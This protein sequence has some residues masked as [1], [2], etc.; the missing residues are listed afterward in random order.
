MDPYRWQRISRLYHAALA[1]ESDRR[2]VF[3]NEACHDDDLR[4]EVE[5]L[6]ASGPGEEGFLDASPVA[7]AAHLFAQAEGLPPVRDQIGAYKILG[8][9]GAGGMGEI[10]RAHDGKLGRDVALKVLPRQLADDPERRARML[11][12]ARAA[13][14][15]NHPNICT[16][17]E[18]G[19]ADGDIYIAMEVIDGEPL[20]ARP[21]GRLLSPEE[22]VRIG[23]QL[24]DAVA[25][26]HD[27]GIVH[28]DLKSGNVMV[29]PEG[30][31]K[32]LDFGLAKRV[33]GEELSD[34]T[35][36]TDV[37]TRPQTILGTLPYMSPEQLRGQTAD[38]RSDVWALGVILYEM[39]AGSR[40][41]DGAT[42]FEMS[43]AIL[44]QTPPAL[45]S[46][47]SVALETVI[48]RCL[49]KEPARRYQRAAEVRAA[50]ETLRGDRVTRAVPLRVKAS[51]SMAAA[52]AVLGVGAAL[53]WV[54]QPGATDSV[55]ILPFINES[56]DPELDYL[57]DGIT[58]TLINSLSQLPELAVMSRNSVFRYKGRETDAQAAG[59]TLKVQ[60]VITGRVLQ[61]GDALSIRAELIDVDSN[62]QL[63]GQQYNRKLVDILTM[64]E[65]ISTQISENLRLRLTGEERKQL[66]KRYTEN[67][68]AYQHYLRGLYHWN[69]RTPD[70]FNRSIEYFQKATAADPNYAPAHAGL[71]N[72]YTNQANYNF[73]LVPPREAWAKAKAASDRALEIDDTL[74]AAH[75]A[76]AL[77]AYQ[78]EWN[79][80]LAE[81][82]FRRA[83]ELDPTSSAT[84]HWYAHYLMTV[85][86][87]EDALKAGRRALELDPLDLPSNAHQGWHYLWLRQYDQAIEPLQM[88]L[89]LAPMFSVAQWYL[90]LAYEQQGAYQQ[91]IGQF[92]NCIRLTDGN[93]S[94]V[95]LLGHAYAAANRRAEAR[96][97]LEQLAVLSKQHYVPSYPV[98]T[99]HAALG[100]KDEAFARLERAYDERDS[101]MDYLA[102][103]PRLDGLR[104]DPRFVNLLRRMNLETRGRAG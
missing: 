7:V 30:R 104:S 34:V 27:R 62:R 46:R 5:S 43:S 11:R 74:A 53:Y 67:T 85:G 72:V 82:E 100:E 79:W 81:K 50:L 58:E 28:R 42:Q 4:R 8:L 31:V 89:E 41:F 10:F 78:W 23:L 13:A 29:T 44:H 68:E 87:T 96:A 80:S 54:S 32:V 33:S 60:A 66:T 71:A 70:G 22:V 14:S 77:M 6:L 40:P 86:R 94:M 52:L 49:D 15:L 57:S 25:H 12:E 101:W 36:S 1:H 16:V 47:V 24:A 83:L 63:W 37:L 39:A 93:P 95:A 19:E 56:G 17:H 9:L 84:Y 26:A 102:L 76:A 99:I 103:D 48:G 88:T 98:A 45:P 18:V 38:A 35:R 73:A 64:Q 91:A 59:R 51:I 2:Q 97:I 21:A 20:S 92:E 3:L 65:E 55:A 75:G 61:R 90:G 69:R